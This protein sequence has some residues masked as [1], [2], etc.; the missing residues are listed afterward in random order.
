M[1]TPA[2]R[3]TI[4]ASAAPCVAYTRVSKEDQARD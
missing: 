2:P 3:P 1:T 4:T